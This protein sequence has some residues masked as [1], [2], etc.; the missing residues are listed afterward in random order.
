MNQRRGAYLVLASGLGLIACETE[1]DSLGTQGDAL[2]LAEC[3]GTDC[4]ERVGTETVQAASVGQCD[5]PAEHALELV[6]ERDLCGGACDPKRLVAARDGTA[7]LLGI[8]E[9][10]DR[11]LV[12]SHVAVDGSLLGEVDVAAI[13]NPNT[14]V[15]V[16][17]ACDERSHCYVS[18]YT[19]YAETADSELI[20]SA[21]VQE[22]DAL[23]QPVAAA[24]PL[25]GVAQPLVRAGAAGRFALA[26]PTW[27]G[28][29]RGSLALL[30]AGALVFTH[31]NLNTYGRLQGAGVAGLAIDDDGRTAVLAERN[32]Q[33]GQPASFSLTRFDATGSPIWDRTLG[34]GFENGSRASLIAD[35]AGNLTVAG[36]VPP[37]NP[38]LF[39]QEI[40]VQSLD[41]EGALRWA[42]QLHWN[43]PAIAVDAP[44]GR[45][46]ALSHGNLKTYEDPNA[47][48]WQGVDTTLGYGIIEEITDAGTSCRRYS[49][50]YTG[51]F[52]A[53]DLGLG[54]HDDVYL[55]T[56]R[57][58]ARHTGIGQSHDDGVVVGPTLPNR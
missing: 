19:L 56:A 26:G 15:E 39:V 27:T 24:I 20:Q 22:F 54:T 18:W 23:V 44:T 9:Q 4:D 50:A 31:N 37:A 57:G 41:A 40:H 1:D 11:V 46:F 3:W 29:H 43:W 55:V 12:L 52:L 34:F 48:A 13:S 25:S 8:R 17:L 28:A 47:G 32:W 33:M 53:G 36:F 6:W 16:D 2:N 58:L 35:D 14:Q 49:Y 45:V 51:G 30:D 10:G 38:A 5:L 7:W 21:H 42:Y